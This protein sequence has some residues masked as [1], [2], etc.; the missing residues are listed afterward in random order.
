[1][2]HRPANALQ[3]V[4]R[5]RSRQGYD[6]MN[7][8]GELWD[9]LSTELRDAHQR[10]LKGTFPVVKLKQ[11]T[12]TVVAKPLEPQP[13]EQAW[14][15]D[16]I[17]S[18]SEHVFRKGS[19]RSHQ[20]GPSEAKILSTSTHSNESVTKPKKKKTRSQFLRHYFSSNRHTKST[21]SGSSGDTTAGDESTTGYYGHLSDE[22]WSSLSRELTQKVA[23]TPKC[24]RRLH[25]HDNKATVPSRPVKREAVTDRIRPVATDAEADDT[26]TEYGFSS[27][28]VCQRNE[29][30]MSMVGR[31]EGPVDGAVLADL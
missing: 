20:V 10:R 27:Q 12:S 29:Y 25:G 18:T 16:E 19:S 17:V 26:S 28:R 31:R 24:G 13:E 8:S 5:G 2:K 7:R 23:K 4:W 14:I 1:M 9:A 30:A 3:N 15:V 6:Q 11:N 21:S 22:L